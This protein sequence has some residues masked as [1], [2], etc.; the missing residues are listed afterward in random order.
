MHQASGPQTRLNLSIAI[1]FG[2]FK[3]RHASNAPEKPKRPSRGQ[4]LCLRSTSRPGPSPP[5]ETACSSSAGSTGHSGKLRRH[6]LMTGLNA[7]TVAG[8]HRWKGLAYDLWK[9]RCHTVFWSYFLTF[10]IPWFEKAYGRLIPFTASMVCTFFVFSGMK[11]KPLVD[12]D[13]SSKL[14]KRSQQLFL[15]IWISRVEFDVQKNASFIV[16]KMNES[17]AYIGCEVSQGDS[18]LH[19]GYSNG[20]GPQTGRFLCQRSQ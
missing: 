16:S 4:F 1:T 11:N 19:T 20:N 5:K 6:S 14:S 13:R 3:R 7:G 12:R 10:C 9:P 15:E 2:C 8:K 18:F 17:G